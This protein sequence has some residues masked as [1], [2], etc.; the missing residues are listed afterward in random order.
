MESLRNADQVEH[1]LIWLRRPGAP[2]AWEPFRLRLK[3]EAARSRARRMSRWQT[4]PHRKSVRIR[5]QVEGAACAL[6]PPALAAALAAL[7]LEA[8]VPLAMGLE[9]TPRPALH[10]AHPLPLDIPGQGEWA[11]LVLTQ[12]AD[13]TLASLPERINAYSR[14]GLRVLE[15]LAIPN[16]ATPVAELCTSAL[17][18]WSCPPEQ[19]PAAEGRVAEFL[20]AESFLFEK[21]G[22]TDGHKGVKRVE[23]RSLVETMTW[24]RANLEF[25]TR[26]DAGQAPNPRKLLGAVLGVEPAAILGL[27]RLGLALA[28]DPRL[29]QADRFEPKL[30]NMFEDAVLLESGSNIRIVEGDDDDPIILGG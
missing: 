21:S 30:H 6:H 3:E 25:R 24:D 11:D 2:K 9:K 7:L 1:A 29:L 27:E 13:G 26:I 17:W 5:F 23:I 20:A 15:C 12:A 8:G 16:Y 18:R 4:D 10:L 14:G 22:K 19:R 28:E